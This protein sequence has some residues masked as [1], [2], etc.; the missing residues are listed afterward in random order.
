ML[1]VGLNLPTRLAGDPTPQRR[2]LAMAELAD[3]NTGWDHVWVGD[4]AIA[5]RMYE[6]IVLLSA[7]AAVTD[8]VRLGIGCMATLGLRH[9]LLLAQ[10]LA[11]L[12]A[13]SEG[14]LTLV[15]CP[16]WGSGEHVKRELAAFRIS[17]S[18]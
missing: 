4:S 3:G 18:E 10:Q 2:L 14:R 13:L 17:Y 5:L 15:A 1:D 12:D 9:P 7:C 16:G 8:R 6:P 11:N